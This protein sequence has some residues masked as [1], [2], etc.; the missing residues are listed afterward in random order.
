MKHFTVVGSGLAG[1]LM[2]IYL[3]KR[4]YGVTLY[5]RN[6]DM[7]DRPVP[8]GRSIN[9]ALSR[10]GLDALAEVGLADRLLD[11]AIPMRGRMM[12]AVDGKLTFQPYGVRDDQVIYSISR[13]ALNTALLNRAE[14]FE[15]VDIHF[16]H[17][18]VGADLR[19]TTLDF[20]DTK[21]GRTKTVDA[22]VVVA[23]D[24][25]FSAV[26][27]QIQMLDRSDYSQEFL[28]HGYKELTIPPFP[29][30]SFALDKNCL[31]IWPRHDFMLIAL[32][33]LDGSFTCTLFLA[34]EGEKSFAALKT[35]ED[36][37]RF[38]VTHFPDVVPLMPT[39]LDDFT[40]N[41]T[42][43]MVT[44]R[45]RPWHYLDR[46]A[47]VGDAAHA[48]VPFY[49]Q[50]MNASFEDCSVLD[51]CLDAHGEDLWTAFREYG[52]RRKPNTD[53]LSRLAYANFLEMRAKVASPAFL[54]KKKI[55]GLLTTWFPDR[56]IPL[57]TM[58]TFT[59]I[60]YAEAAERARKQDRMLFAAGLG[61]LVVLPAVA[62]LLAL[63]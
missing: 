28:T 41:P 23:A 52:A 5:E 60:P 53:A 30:G 63:I 17:K 8:R 32:P 43:S 38:F 35:E 34:F 26:R 22:E 4:G 46:F 57:Y 39:L 20:E 13:G 9:L 42:G 1:S 61:I 40:H 48:V 16:N 58:V 31:H 12:H 21:T 11:L 6:D 49:G 29:D 14:T 27:K 44:V 19:A 15:N 62:F 37:R 56:F 25:A 54:F 55:E 59:R 10:R 45:C 24:G 47:L 51:E 3:A 33:N 2:A 7:R 18:C 50:G 36:V